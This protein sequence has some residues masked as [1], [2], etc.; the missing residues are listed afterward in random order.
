[1]FKDNLD[2]ISDNEEDDDEDDDN[3]TVTVPSASQQSGAEF[4]EIIVFTPQRQ[5]SSQE[6]H[7]PILDNREKSKSS[8]YSDNSGYSGYY[9][10]SGNNNSYEGQPKNMGNSYQ[11][12]MDKN[13][14]PI[15][16]NTQNQYHQQ[17]HGYNQHQNMHMPQHRPQ[18]YPQQGQ[19]HQSGPPHQPYY[20][21]N[22]HHHQQK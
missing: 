9:Q 20:G 14:Q 19:Y 10:G 3:I 2:Q 15:P 8:Q 1:M 4:R 16:V 13:Y 18:Q 11:E 22:H 6:I 5:D 21:H 12:N 17:Q 7:E